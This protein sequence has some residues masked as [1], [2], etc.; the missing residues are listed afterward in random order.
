MDAATLAAAFERHLT[1]DQG[2]ALEHASDRDRFEILAAAIREGIA[3]GWLGT[4]EAQ[5]RAVLE[6]RAIDLDHLVAP[7]PDAG[8]DNGGL[9]RLAACFLESL[10]TL[11]FPAMGY[12][13]RYEYGMFRQEIVDGW[14]V[15]HPDNWLR[16]SDPWELPRRH[17]AVNAQIGCALK[18]E[19]G[20]ARLLEDHA[21]TLRGIPY[22]RPI[23]GFWGADDQ[24]AALVEGDITGLLRSQRVQSR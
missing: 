21:A 13:L 1:R 9:G 17:H 2:L 4:D 10:A 6:R 18:F 22:D 11:H 14:Q 15:E 19:E 23:V 8:L 3:A 12:G 20:G 24:H 7:E 16:R 5:V